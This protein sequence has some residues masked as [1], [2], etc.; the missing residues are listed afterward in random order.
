M[1]AAPF[2]ASGMATLIKSNLTA[3]YPYPITAVYLGDTSNLGSTSA[4]LNQSSSQPQL[5]LRSLHHQTHRPKL[6]RSHSSPGSPRRRSY[7]L[8]R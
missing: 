1:G 8:A 4:V 3:T 2:N 7:P 6:T 5:R